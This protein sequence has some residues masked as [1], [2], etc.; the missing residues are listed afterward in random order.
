MTETI[1]VQTGPLGLHFTVPVISRGEGAR[2]W[3]LQSPAS[4]LFTN[5][6][7]LHLSPALSFYMY[8]YFFLNGYNI[9]SLSRFIKIY[10]HHK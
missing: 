6:L 8:I 10:L 9:T 3:V 2:L 1:R 4:A 5:K 7:N